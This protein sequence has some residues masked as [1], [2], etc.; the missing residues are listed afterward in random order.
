MKLRSLLYLSAILCTFSYSINTYASCH[1]VGC[2]APERG[3]AGP[4]GPTGPAGPT[5]ATGAT[6]AGD[7]ISAYDLDLRTVGG[8]GTAPLA[9]DETSVTNGGIAHPG[10]ILFTVSKTGVYLV[11]WTIT[12]QNTS[13]NTR[14]SGSINLLNNTTSVFY[15]PSPFS[16]QQVPNLAGI[17]QGW[18]T[19]SGQAL[20]NISA[21]QSISLLVS[22]TDVSSFDVTNRTLLITQIAN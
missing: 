12:L 2:H 1:G 13:S 17:A 14:V 21:G 11:C 15:Q 7:Y 4:T 8:G 9:F 6:F 16:S 5:G 22:N 18:T 10:G 20:V 3:P 19:V